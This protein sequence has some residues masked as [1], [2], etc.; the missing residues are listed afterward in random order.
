MISEYTLLIPYSREYRPVKAEKLKASITGFLETW[1]FSFISSAFEKLITTMWKR[2]E[3]KHQ[4]TSNIK[5]T[6]TMSY[7]NEKEKES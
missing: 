5:I 7:S 6:V 1:F 2:S 4:S 3:A